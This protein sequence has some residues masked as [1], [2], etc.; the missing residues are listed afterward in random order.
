MG[1][2]LIID[3]GELGNSSTAAEHKGGRVDDFHFSIVLSPFCFLLIEFHCTF[4]FLGKYYHTMFIIILLRLG[5]DKR[6]SC[7]Y[8]CLSQRTPI[9]LS[10]EMP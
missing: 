8:H 1:S 9:V 7:F 3:V 10:P 6:V 5:S 4:P 2:G